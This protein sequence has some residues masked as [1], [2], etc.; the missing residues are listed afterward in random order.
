M[1][2]FQRKQNRSVILPVTHM[3]TYHP[4]ASSSHENTT[5]VERS[6]SLVPNRLYLSVE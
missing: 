4:H 3:K 6:G 2:W 1:C 5:E